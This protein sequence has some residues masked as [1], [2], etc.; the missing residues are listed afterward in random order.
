MKN[1][2]YDFINNYSDSWTSEELEKMITISRF[3]D[4]KWMIDNLVHQW[5]HTRQSFIKVSDAVRSY[6]GYIVEVAAGPTGGFASA[7]LVDNPQKK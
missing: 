7:Y 5:Q 1:G 6:D 2:S 4:T 3:S